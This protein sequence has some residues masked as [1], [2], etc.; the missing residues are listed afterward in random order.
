MT[1]ETLTETLSAIGKPLHTVGLPD[2]TR[3]LLLPHGGRILGLFGPSSEE[4][5]YWTNPALATPESAAAYYA[6]GDWQNSGGDRTWL[7]PELDL[8]FPQYPQVDLSSYFQPRQLDPGCYTAEIRDGTVRMV[9]RLSLRFYRQGTTAELE[10]HKWVM[11]AANPLRHEG[12]GSL[13]REVEYAGYAQHTMLVLADGADTRVGLWNLT[14]MPHGGEMLIPV[15]RRSEPRVYFGNIAS[16]TL[17]LT[18]HVI[19]WRMDAPGEQK[20]GVRATA[21]TGRIGYRFDQGGSSLLIIRNFAVDSSGEYIDVPW[22]QPGDLGYAVQA[23]NVSSRWGQF[24]ELEYHSPAIGAGTGVRSC[25]DISQVWSFRGSPHG[26]D[27]IVS[28]LL[29]PAD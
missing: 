24:N 17:R 27:E 10:I 18:D 6:S 3:I 12:V 19:R 11:P 16:G 22:D 23:C 4:N 9:N 14:Q 2:G 29:C 13:L 8:F 5:I 20:I 7:S 1:Y 15:Y 25:E 21:T 28:R 26:I